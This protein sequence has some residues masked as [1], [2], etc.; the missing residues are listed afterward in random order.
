[1]DNRVFTF[2]SIKFFFTRIFSITELLFYEMLGTMRQKVCDR[3]R[4]LTLLSIKVFD[5]QNIDKLKESPANNLGVV[6]QKIS[7]GIS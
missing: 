5:T 7:A 6:K 4:E 1:M 2:L 3:I